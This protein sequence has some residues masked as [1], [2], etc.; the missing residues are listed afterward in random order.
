[1]MRRRVFLGFLGLLIVSSLLV[2]PAAA[3][4]E[5]RIAISP[6]YGPPGTKFYI[7]VTGLVENED[8]SIAIFSYAQGMA[9]GVKSFTTD[10]NG[11]LSITFDSTGVEPGAYLPDW[12]GVRNGD[13]SRCRI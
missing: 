1:M 3:A 9:I 2:M 8:Y 10:Q 7:P 4:A 6:G 5:T 13:S 12:G 11:T